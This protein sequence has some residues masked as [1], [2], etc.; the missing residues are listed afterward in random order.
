MAEKILGRSTIEL[1]G[2]NTTYTSQ[3]YQATMSI[4]Y[5]IERLS[6]MNERLFIDSDG[7]RSTI[8]L[9]VLQLLKPL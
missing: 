4:Y 1:K 3:R 2:A 7:S 9:K 5:R 6:I 8:E